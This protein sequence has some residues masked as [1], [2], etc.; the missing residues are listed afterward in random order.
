MRLKQQKAN[1]EKQVQAAAAKKWSA[2]SYQ[3]SPLAP[4]L[5]NNCI[6]Y[7]CWFCPLLYK[8]E[9]ALWYKW[10]SFISI[11]ASKVTLL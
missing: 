6:I 10:N 1:E 9:C 3:F 8:E 7:K 5:K 2:I 4:D 11:R